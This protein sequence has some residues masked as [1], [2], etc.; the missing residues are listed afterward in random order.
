MS[1]EEDISWKSKG[2]GA[3]HLMLCFSPFFFKIV[4]LLFLLT[5]Q[6]KCFLFIDSF[7]KYL[8]CTHYV[9]NMILSMGVQ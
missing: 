4:S 5:V 9:P 3:R 8:L 7:S 6:V 2:G 1:V